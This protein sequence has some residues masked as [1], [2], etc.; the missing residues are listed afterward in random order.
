MF[1]FFDD[2]GN[3]PVSSL[4]SNMFLVHHP[5]KSMLWHFWLDPSEKTELY[6]FFSCSIAGRKKKKLLGGRREDFRVKVKVTSNSYI[7]YSVAVETLRIFP[8]KQ[9]V[10]SV[11]QVIRHCLSDVKA[12]KRHSLLLYR[13]ESRGDDT[14][15]CTD[16]RPTYSSLPSPWW[17]QPA[18]KKNCLAWSHS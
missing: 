4:S 1:R 16:S 13:S 17:C 12:K 10:T 11:C 7:V 3:F 15:L 14:R 18:R 9:D 5:W 2:S 6:T 8:W